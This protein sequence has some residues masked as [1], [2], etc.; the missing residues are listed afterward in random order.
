MIGKFNRSLE[1]ENNIA[2]GNTAAPFTHP[3]EIIEAEE[4]HDELDLREIGRVPVDALAAFLRFILP[5]P[6]KK[7]DPVD[8][9]RRWDCAKLR[10]AVLAKA[11]LPEVREMSETQ[12][13]AELGVT[14]SAISKACVPLRD[15]AG[16]TCHDGR[17]QTAREVYRQRQ[18][19]AWVK[20]KA[21]G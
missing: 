13:A 19:A 7:K 4:Q 16:L 17:T 6:V 5:P 14:R 10:L 8:P 12:L 11:V 15:F 20:K 21:E 1:A 9:R 2:T 18:K 3:S